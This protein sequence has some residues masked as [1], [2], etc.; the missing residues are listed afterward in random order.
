MVIHTCPPDFSIL[1]IL[2]SHLLEKWKWNIQF[3]SFFGDKYL[4]MLPNCYHYLIL[5]SVY[6]NLHST[7]GCLVVMVQTKIPLQI[8]KFLEDITWR[9]SKILRYVLVIKLFGHEIFKYNSISVLKYVVLLGD[10]FDVPSA[11]EIWI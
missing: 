1:C 9:L 10:E 3:I 8:Y 5:Q 11:V 4:Y 7:K 6:V 2:C